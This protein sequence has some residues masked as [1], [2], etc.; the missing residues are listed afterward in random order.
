MNSNIG[1][2]SSQYHCVCNNGFTT[3]DAIRTGS[4][5]PNQNNLARYSTSFM[6]QADFFKTLQQQISSLDLSVLDSLLGF[7]ATQLNSSSTTSIIVPDAPKDYT[8]HAPIDIDFS[9][10][11]PLP[12]MSIL[13]PLDNKPLNETMP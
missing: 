13:K 3:L 7:G 1:L 9:K 12:D 6:S 5:S 8:Y 4:Q 11:I 10:L 2:T